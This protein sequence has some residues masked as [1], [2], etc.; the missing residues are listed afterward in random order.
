EDQ[1]KLALVA[2]A[3]TEQLV[4]TPVS[5]SAE[6][7][8]VDRRE[9]RVSNRALHYRITTTATGHHA[10]EARYQYAT[11]PLKDLRKEWAEY[12]ESVYLA[13]PLR[14]FEHTNPKELDKPFV[15]VAEGEALTPIPSLEPELVI[16][17]PVG[18]GF[19]DLPYYLQWKQDE[20]EDENDS[21][22]E[23]QPN[24]PAAKAKAKTKKARGVVLDRLHV[25]ELE[26]VVTPP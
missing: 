7:R 21:D 8:F 3:Q 14:R 17:V 23:D 22:D 9:V 24:T 26:F 6:N 18:L 10:T 25:R 1:G 2:T 5:A 19:E 12:L 16:P 15:V 13:K 11:T 20:E 4:R